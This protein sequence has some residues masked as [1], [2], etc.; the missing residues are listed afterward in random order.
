ML[1]VLCVCV[2]IIYIYTFYMHVRMY[3]IYESKSQK[4]RRSSDLCSNAD[5]WCPQ[6][7]AIPREKE[8]GLLGPQWR[9]PGVGQRKVTRYD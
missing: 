4:G 2:R 9:I 5:A 3:E 7:T 8:P 6:L 1:V